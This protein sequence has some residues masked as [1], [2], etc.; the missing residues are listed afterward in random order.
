VERIDKK[1]AVFLHV[2]TIGR[3]QEVANE[4]LFALR[5]LGL[6]EISHRIEVNIVGDGDFLL[7]YSA[8]NVFA[9]R[10][11]SD[12]RLFEF[13]TLNSM[14]EYASRHSDSLLLYLNCLGGRYVGPG[15]EIRWQWRRLLELM[16][17]ERFQ[18][19]IMLLNDHDICGIEWSVRPMPHMTS[20]NWWAHAT[21]IANLP[22]TE[23]FLET[24]L[25]VDLSGYGERWR[26]PE[27]L[28]RHAAEFWIGAD[29]RP[30]PANLMPLTQFGLPS[31]SGFPEANSI[32]SLGG[33]CP[34]LTGQ[35]QLDE[36]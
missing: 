14:Q 18:Q 7:P 29:P 26:N 2:A 17:I 33:T 10:R 15:W 16:L 21:Y 24:V 8:E 28:R 3:Y 34:V 27:V 36:G 1:I 9:I 32:P 5:D 6:S 19:C 12:V 22:K 13:P 11:G 25:S 20:N 23:I 31:S 30:R 4:M 35:A